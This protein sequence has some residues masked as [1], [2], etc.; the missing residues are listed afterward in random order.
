MKAGKP[1]F[2]LGASRLSPARPQQSSALRV[3]RGSRG[4]GSYP[5]RAALAPPAHVFGLNAGQLNSAPALV[6]VFFLLSLSA[7][8][9]LPRTEQGGQ[10]GLSH[11]SLPR[12]SVCASRKAEA[13]YRE[14]QKLPDTKK[15]FTGAAVALRYLSFSAMI[16][17]VR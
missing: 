12:G 13:P 5:P 16:S 11:P 1:C 7:F 15:A 6:C 3:G 17:L 8:G 10:E 14:L 4:L 2:A 9:Q